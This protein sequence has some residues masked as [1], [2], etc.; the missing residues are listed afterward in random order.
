MVYNIFQR[1]HSGW[2]YLTLLLGVL[3]LVIVIFYAVNKRERD[4]FI[5]KLSLVTVII[6]HV[7][8]VTGAALYFLSP[9]VEDNIRPYYLEHPV[10]MLTSVLLITV[11]YAKI[12][13]EKI[14]SL[15]VVIPVA[16][17]IFCMLL[18]IPWDAWATWAR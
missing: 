14:I 1:F 5:K 12:K 11:A 2:A 8:M 4:R 7:Q 15:G 10:M 13:R 6:F 9:K 16:V 3:F 17:S 18:M